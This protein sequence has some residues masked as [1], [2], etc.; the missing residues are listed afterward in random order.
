M[1][2]ADWA[3]TQPRIRTLTGGVD[4]TNRASVRVLEKCG[5]ELI[6]GPDAPEMAYQLEI[7]RS[8]EWD[9]RAV[10]IPTAAPVATLRRRSPR[11]DELVARLRGGGLF[12]QWDWERTDD[13]SHGLTRAEVR[14]TLGSAGLVDV[15]VSD[16]FSISVD[17]QT[18]S[19]IMGYG[20]RSLGIARR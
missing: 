10:G 18:M 8:N 11:C 12:V 6:D 4:P 9:S 15:T 1:G 5:F 20:Q 14:E 19:P 3:R 13:D 16:A 2:L 17:D 7:A